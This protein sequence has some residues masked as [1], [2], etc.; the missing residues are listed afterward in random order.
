MGF[1]FQVVTAAGTG[2]QAAF[3][4]TGAALGLLVGLYMLPGIV[5]A[6][7]GGWL[8]Q[9]F[10]DKRMVLA[11]LATMAIGA[12]VCAWADSWS[13]MV[14]GRALSGFG[15]ILLNVLLTKMTADWFDSRDLTFA[16]G[17]LVTSWPLGIAL[18]MVTLPGITLSAGWEAAFLATAALA[19]LCFVL[20]WRVY[21][22][23]R[24]PAP[25][26]ARLAFRLPRRELA[27]TLLAGAAWGFYNIAFIVLLAFGPAFLVAQGSGEIAAQATVSA[28]SW[29]IIPTIAAAGWIA[30][31]SGRPVLLLAGGLT[32]TA[33]LVF[34]L[35]PTGGPLILFALIGLMI[36]FPAPVLMA[37]LAQTAPTER[38]AV[39]AGLFFT[40]YYLGM[41]IG[42]PVAGWLRDATGTAAAPVWFAGLMLIAAL[43][44]AALFRILQARAA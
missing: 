39:A 25:G 18:A 2:L 1:Q 34:L 26:A 11:G 35:S 41:A 23:A 40:C 7:P 42:S 32:A 13:A 37:M 38:R 28:I 20:I 22:P 10:G 5:L 9:R 3:D 24:A 44:P 33:G 12:A 8:G 29:L 15:A 30:A 43:A 21:R 27:L 6:I 31:R 4:L 36:G 14:A 19:A 16:M 17:I